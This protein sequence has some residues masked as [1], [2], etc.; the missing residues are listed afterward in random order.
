MVK[1]LTLQEDFNFD[2]EFPLASLI[3][4]RVG[5]YYLYPQIMLTMKDLSKR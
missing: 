5:F 4:Q 2:L 1:S 3:I